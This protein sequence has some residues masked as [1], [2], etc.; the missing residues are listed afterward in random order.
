MVRLLYGRSR[1]G[2]KVIPPASGYPLGPLKLIAT[3][4]R[5]SMRREK[6]GLCLG[7]GCGNDPLLA[8]SVTGWQSGDLCSRVWAAR[9]WCWRQAEV[10]ACATIEPRSSES[11]AQTAL[12]AGG[13]TRTG[14]SEWGRQCSAAASSQYR[15]IFRSPLASPPGSQARTGPAGVPRPVGGVPVH[16]GPAARSP[17]AVTM[18][19]AC[20]QALTQRRRGAA[21]SGAISGAVLS[22]L[23][24][25][26]VQSGHGTPAGNRG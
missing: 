1:R 23:L 4:R 11:S 6:K 3:I 14:R 5:K 12:A 13:P 8:S 21:R 16:G 7:C 9:A 10:T 20:A 25:S 19:G 2:R 24:C 22:R 15:R 17:M 18:P 26:V